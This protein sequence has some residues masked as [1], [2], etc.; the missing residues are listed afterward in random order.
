MGEGEGED[1]DE[2]EDEGEGDDSCASGRS[3]QAKEL[4]TQCW[5][6]VMARVFASFDEDPEDC[7]GTGTGTGTLVLV[8]T[9]ELLLLLKFRCEE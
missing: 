9:E 4:I 1:E 2:D 8:E 3:K 5:I 7:T 6:A